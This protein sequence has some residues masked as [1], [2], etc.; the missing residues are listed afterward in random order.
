MESL[1]YLLIAVLL[2]TCYDILMKPTSNKQSTLLYP[3]INTSIR[4]ESSEIKTATIIKQRLLQIYHSEVED[5][6]D[7]IVRLLVQ[8]E[9][10]E[11]PDVFFND[12]D[13]IR[14]YIFNANN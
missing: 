3:E 2:S 1:I 12:N 13:H 11:D 6:K 7:K 8:L 9:R 4:N 14:S 5:K 10:V